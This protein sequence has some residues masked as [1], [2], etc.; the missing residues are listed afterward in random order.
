MG[1][2]IIQCCSSVAYRKE[3]SA[4]VVLS[5]YPENVIQNYAFSVIV[6]AE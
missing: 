1:E 4:P 5:C 3:E 2:G 6:L